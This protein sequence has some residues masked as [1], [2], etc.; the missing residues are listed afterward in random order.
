[1]S[2]DE[3]NEHPNNCV[4]KTPVDQNRGELLEDVFLEPILDM[5]R[6][7][8][9]TNLEPH[10][11]QRVAVILAAALGCL[12]SEVAAWGELDKHLM[13]HVS[14]LMHHRPWRLEIRE[15]IGVTTEQA[16]ALHGRIRSEAFAEQQLKDHVQKLTPEQ[17]N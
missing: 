13:T 15:H 17:I 5:I 6:D 1:M 12:S 16:K 10:D 14:G 4:L 8:L 2:D 11:R 7:M 9:G 3:T